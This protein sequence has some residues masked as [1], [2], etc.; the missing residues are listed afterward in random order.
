[1]DIYL[2][3]AEIVASAPLP[4]MTGWDVEATDGHIGKVD[5]ATYESHEVG[6]HQGCLVVDTGFWIFGKKRL[7]PAGVVTA[8]DPDERKVLVAMA[9]DDVKSA[10]DYHHER[11]R[12]DEH[13][14]H[15]DE[16]TY[17]ERF[18]AEV[19]AP[20]QTPPRGG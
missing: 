13:G 2:Y 10:P 14:Y 7:L 4:D 1:M 5:E 16:R 8:L 18:G 6:N 17:Y 9:K 20:V 11:H 19:V 15:D 12:D 3:R